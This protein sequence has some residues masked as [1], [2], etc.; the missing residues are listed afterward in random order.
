[1][2][3]LWQRYIFKELLK[4]FLFFLLCFF[5]LYSLIDLSTHVQDFSKDGKIEAFKALLYYG[6]QFF[7]KLRLLL[8]LAVLISSIKVLSSL[9]MHRELLALQ[10]SGIPLKKIF[11][12]FWLLAFLCMTIGFVNEE[13]ICPTSTAYLEE[14][15][16][17][18][19]DNPL[20]KFKR[21]Q[22]AVLYLKDSSRLIYQRF[23]KEKNAFF[24]VYWIRSFNDI[25]KIKYLNADPHKT[26]GQY[27]DHLIRNE[28]GFL[29]KKESYEQCLL[30]SLKWKTSELRKKQSS[31]KNQR[32]SKLFSL[33][34]KNDRDSFHARGEISTYFF[35]KAL[36]P[37][38]SFLVLLG[39][40]PYCIIYSRNFPLF[41]LYGGAIFAFALFCTF[42]DAMIIIAEN[43]IVHPAIALGLPFLAVLAKTYRTFRLIQ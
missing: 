8:P 4:C 6:H 24:D 43:Q 23:D 41:L 28:Q 9:N 33:L 11:R 38:L 39:I 10:A 17:A 1:M 2:T 31:I 32:F 30:P 20:E 18:R 3:F 19:M 40:L 12:P 25:W 16:Q 15:K 42:T 34:L 37:F 36:M 14:A 13:V 26:L 35:Y 22:F 5:L 29:E 27:V 21:K 7:K